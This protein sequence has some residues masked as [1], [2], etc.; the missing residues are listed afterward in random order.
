M[1]EE[2]Y[3]SILGIGRTASLSEIKKAYKK[4]VRK[5]HPDL[6]PNDSSSEE[7]F[8]KI[9]EA[10]SALNDP[11]KKEVYDK[12]GKA[13]LGSDFSNYRVYNPS[14]ID[15]EGFDF[16]N[17]GTSSFKDV[18]SHLFDNMRTSK[19]QQYKTE[20]FETLD[21][22]YPM[23]ITF[24]ESIHGL[25]AE[26][27]LSRM[28]NCY[29][30][31]GTGFSKQ[32]QEVVCSICNGTGRMSKAR[33]Y[34]RFETSCN[35]CDGKGKIT[36]G[37]CLHCGGK[38]KVSKTERMK[39]KIPPGTDNNSRIRVT[40]K[41]NEGKT[42]SKTG[43]LYLAITVNPHPIFT[44][45]GDN[46]YLTIPITITEAALGAKIEVPT[47]DGHTTMKIPPNT[48]S[49]QVF[50][51]KGKGSPSLRGNYKGD[52][53]IEVVIWMP[54]IYDEESRDLLKKFNLRHNEN[55]RTEIYRLAAE[56]A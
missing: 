44:R 43:D 46:I 28:V 17:F 13:G 36:K 9:Q 12:Y 15:F 35:T 20:D 18:F 14:D 50:R 6:N 45:K 34:L 33:G 7:K 19:K 52:F 39:V 31:S 22:V 5:Y 25:T 38:G 40:G 29:M 54:E 51:L 1:T 55:P 27:S 32:A 23:S 26:I 3:Y 48:K 24:M 37:K 56:N 42:T 11:K 4:L 8:K 30:C 10:Y 41:G 53:Y 21:I 49:G 2:D 47:I 16:T